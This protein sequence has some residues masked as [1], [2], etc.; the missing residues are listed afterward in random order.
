MCL[1]CSDPVGASGLAAA[2]LGVCALVVVCS[3]HTDRGMHAL[4]PV[5]VSV[6]AGEA[7]YTISTQVLVLNSSVGLIVIRTHILVCCYGRGRRVIQSWPLLRNQGCTAGI[8]DIIHRV[9][10]LLLLPSILLRQC[11]IH[12]AY[13]NL[14]ST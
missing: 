1:A 9:P 4:M 7:L 12:C 11:A 5:V 3:V 10:I 6:R 14:W 2:A 8:Q 13:Y